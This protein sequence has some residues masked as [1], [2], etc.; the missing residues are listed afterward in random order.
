MKTAEIE[1]NG[2]KHL[3]CFNLYA[4]KQCCERYG[5]FA[6]IWEALSKENE[7]ERIEESLWIMETMMKGGA[8]Y[9]KE[10]GMENAEPLTAGKMQIVCGADFFLG[11]RSQLMGAIT[12]GMKADV[13]VEDPKKP[14]TTQAK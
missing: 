12:S 1:I 14:E 7:A 8:M 10:M 3:L 9:A 13:E 11:L 6:G 2:T 4:V 5:S